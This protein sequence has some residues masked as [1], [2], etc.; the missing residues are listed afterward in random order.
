MAPLR[1]RYSEAVDG[2]LPKFRINLVLVCNRRLEGRIFAPGSRDVAQ[3]A[4]A[5]AVFM[6]VVFRMHLL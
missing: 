2:P 6:L 4:L 5:A 3:I 1:N